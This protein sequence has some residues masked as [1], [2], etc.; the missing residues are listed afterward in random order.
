MSQEHLV[1]LREKLSQKIAPWLNLMFNSWSWILLTQPDGNEMAELTPTIHNKCSPSTA[2]CS[3]RSLRGSS[4]QFRLRWAAWLA[5]RGKA[6]QHMWI[7][8]SPEFLGFIY[9]MYLSTIFHVSGADYSLCLCC[10]QINTI[11]V[12]SESTSIQNR[13]SGINIFNIS[14]PFR[15]HILLFNLAVGKKKSSSGSESKK[16]WQCK[17]F[18]CHSG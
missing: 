10:L 13:S 7:L 15:S 9:A 12:T 14:Q 6:V 8:C 17:Y 4:C 18:F 2:S 3:P 16:I 1:P 11:N 5:V